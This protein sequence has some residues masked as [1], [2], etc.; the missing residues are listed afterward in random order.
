LKV[1][2]TVADHYLPVLRVFAHQFEKYWNDP[3]WT[4][5]VLGFKQPSFKLPA[6]FDFV[7]MGNMEDFPFNRWTDA[8]G[9][10]L[11]SINDEVF[12]LMLEDYILSRPVNT[13]AV[14][15]LFDYMVQ[16]K[17]VIKV[18]LCEDRLYAYGADL[19]YSWVDYIDLI[20]S[21]PGS[22]YHMSLWP[23]L[24]NRKHFLDIIEPGW[25]P[26]DVELQG[27]PKLSHRSDLLVLGTRQSPVRITNLVRANPGQLDLSGLSSVDV[28]AM[29]E[30]GI[31]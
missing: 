9:K 12:C 8:V 1:I 23:G 31:L 25:S 28:Q 20:K 13:N 14:R 16:F 22:P 11:G 15:I 21:M 2:V 5:T 10:Y 30:K 6:H 4:V 17:Y 24:W 3:R 26:H 7:S 27:T 29:K 19:A 18:D